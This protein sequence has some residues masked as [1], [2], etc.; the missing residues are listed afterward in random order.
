M[1]DA[2]LFLV[3]VSISATILLPAMTSDIP[4]K[5]LVQQHK[6]SLVNDA[7]LMLQSSKADFIQYDF[8]G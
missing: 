3:M 4:Q 6:Q 5:G 2:I 8:E 7:L 1:Q